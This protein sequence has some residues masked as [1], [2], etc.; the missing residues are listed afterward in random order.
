MSEHLADLVAYYVDSGWAVLPIPTGRKGPTLQGWPSITDGRMA[1]AVQENVGINLEPSGLTDIDLDCVEAVALADVF[2]P[3]TLTFGRKSKPKSHFLY[4]GKSKSIKFPFDGKMLVEIRCT[5]AQTMFPPSVHPEGETVEWVE[6]GAA[7]APLPSDLT[8]RVARLASAALLVRLAPARGVRHEYALALGG[9]LAR[10]GWTEDAVRTF[11]AP[12]FEA[13]EFHDLERHVFAA[14]GSVAR[15]RNGEAVTGWS[16]VADL[17]G[18]TGGAAVKA[19]RAWLGDTGARGRQVVSIGL[20]LSD[21]IDRCVEALASTEVYQKAGQLVGV[22]R[23]ATEVNGK[24]SPVDNPSI[25]LLPIPNV[26]ER[27]DQLIQFTGINKDGDEVAVKTPPEIAIK[28]SARGEWS[29]IRPLNNVVG[30]PFLRPDWTIC[31]GGYDPSTRTLCTNTIDL[32]VLDRPTHRDAEIALSILREPF[33][34]ICFNDEIAVSA[35]LSFLLT[36]IARFAIQ[37]APLFVFDAN[38]ERTGKTLLATSLASIALGREPSVAALSMQEDEVRKALFSIAHAGSPLSIFD[39]VRG[40]VES[41]ALE[42]AITSGTISDRILGKSEIVELPCRSVFALTSNNASLSTDLLKRSIAIRLHTD[43]ERPEY[44]TGFRYRLPDVVLQNR[45]VLL[46]AA[47]TVLRAY[48]VAGRPARLSSLG[49]FGSWT[50]A[51]AAPLV[52]LGLPNPIDSQ[53]DFVAGGDTISEPL[54]GLLDVLA[55][56]PEAQPA[57]V[58]VADD[59]LRTVLAEM[60]GDAKI[61]SA[62]LTQH[63]RRF[64]LRNVGGRCI[65]RVYHAHH[66]TYRWY[67]RN[68]EDKPRGGLFRDKQY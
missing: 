28:L 26:E 14:V 17:L 68:V 22:R 4:Q 67:V 11:V 31:T 6:D 23:D 25:R 47:F 58:L 49:S 36:L 37:N 3:P 44:R 29:H 64:R 48:D 5:G 51:V 40:T 65:D 53:I 1:M 34:D 8:V 50:D 33:V 46:S 63:L 27:I 39:N 16:T 41:A 42:A 35:A 55:T 21:R 52:W 56:F 61:T 43:A 54:A 13:S 45:R 66:K 59:R 24:I 9:S 7:L 12:V 19:L 60:F 18:P 10:A 20:P 32:D 57:G 30:Y 62:R 15:V 38:I 2:L